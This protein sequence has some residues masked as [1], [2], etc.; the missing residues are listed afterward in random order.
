VSKWQT[1]E[2]RFLFSKKMPEMALLR[3]ALALLVAHPA[4]AFAP[5]A[6]FG[7][8]ALFRPTASIAAA[9]QPSPALRAAVDPS[10][11]MVRGC[12]MEIA[13]GHALLEPG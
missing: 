4:A 10:D 8:R 3:T 5:A 1:F 11:V 9:S 7:Q 13:K 12:A 6:A 2:I